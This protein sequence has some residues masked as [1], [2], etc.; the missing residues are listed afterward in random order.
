MQSVV[1]EEKLLLQGW[2]PARFDEFEVTVF[3]RAIDFVADERQT[4]RGQMN[5]DLVGAASDRLAIEDAEPAPA[6]LETFDDVELGFCEV[7]GRMNSLFQPDFA[8]HPFALTEERLIDFEVIDLRP[9]LDDGGIKFLDLLPGHEPTEFAGS[10]CVLGD[11]HE[12]AGFTVEPVDERDLASV[13]DFEGEQIAE[14]QPECTRTVRFRR[15]HEEVWGLVHDQEVGFF[16][17]DLEAICVGRSEDHGHSLFP[18]SRCCRFAVFPRE[19]DR[20]MDLMDLMDL[21]D[22][23]DISLVH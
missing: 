11:Q 16:V 23:M 14:L 15:V 10:L 1:V 7:T 13:L 9:T 21:V 4:E 12:S 17:N 19:R 20:L 3:V 18:G 8:W 6:V 2:S 22:L 5:T